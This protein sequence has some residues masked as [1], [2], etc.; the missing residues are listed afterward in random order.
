M[1]TPNFRFGRLNSLVA[2]MAIAMLVPQSAAAL[3]LGAGW[4]RSDVGLH[5]DGEGIYLSV[6]DQVSLH[7][8]VFDLSYALEY[9]QKKGSQPTPFSDPITGFATDDAEVTLHV[10]EP[11]IFVGATA[12][13][14]PLLPRIY[15]GGSIGL[16]VSEQW[17]EFP[18]EPNQNYGYKETD[19]IVHLGVSAAVGPVLVDL[20]WS[21]SAVGQL[22]RDDQNLPLWNANKAD[23]PLADVEAPREG[24]KTEVLRLGVAYSF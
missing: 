21:K 2:M 15:A 17:G 5:D 10:L 3:T 19:I 4:T 11:A 8:S 20:R 1:K 12:P 23:D 24:F 18:G 6:G 14:V 16:K 22:L 9:V 7:Q 13:G